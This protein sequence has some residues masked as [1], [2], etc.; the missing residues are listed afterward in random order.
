MPLCVES[1][2]FQANNVANAY[3]ARKAVELVGGVDPLHCHHNSIVMDKASRQ[4]RELGGFR[5]S[6]AQRRIA[7]RRGH[8]LF[9]A[10]AGDVDIPQLEID[11]RLAQEGASLVAAVEQR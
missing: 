1:G 3:V 8:E 6:T 9:H 2:N 7:E 4:T 10:C 5:K 11:D